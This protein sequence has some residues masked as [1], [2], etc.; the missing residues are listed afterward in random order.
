MDIA[1]TVSET[2]RGLLISPAPRTKPMYIRLRVA[3]PEV[4][5]PSTESLLRG[6]KRS[7]SFCT[8]GPVWA[9]GR[10]RLGRGGQITGARDIPGARLTASQQKE[11]SAASHRL[12]GS[13]KSPMSLSKFAPIMIW[14]QLKV[15]S[16][17]GRGSGNGQWENRDGL[18]RRED[19][20]R[21]RHRARAG[22]LQRTNYG[23]HSRR[24]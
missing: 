12:S 1:A 6:P 8:G 10:R 11:D 3:G 14:V 4:L 5:S 23:G 2:A 17:Q 19:A 13:W 15:S 7:E 20:T 9:G 24:Q 18:A 16:S 21:R 22:R